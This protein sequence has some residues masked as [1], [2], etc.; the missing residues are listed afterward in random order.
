MFIYLP[1]ANMEAAKTLKTPGNLTE[2]HTYVSYMK[3][4]SGIDG[5]TEQQHLLQVRLFIC[6]S[7]VIKKILYINN[8]SL[9]SIAV[10]SYCRS[11]CRTSSF[12]GTYTGRNIVVMRTLLT[13]P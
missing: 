13:M 12:F 11:T 4:K 7:L 9:C 8:L 3:D 2:L 1:V 5:W 6:L 10:S